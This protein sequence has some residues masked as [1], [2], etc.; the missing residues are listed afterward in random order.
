[1][2]KPKLKLCKSCKLAKPIW[3]D[4]EC[5]TCYL[6]NSGVQRGLPRVSFKSKSKLK[7]KRKGKPKEVREFYAKMTE[8]HSSG[9][10]S[11]ESGKPIGNIMAVNMAHIF[12]KER[13]KSLATN[14][15][16]IVILTWEEHTDFDNLLFKHDF[17]RLEIDFKNSWSKICEI[18]IELLPLCV[19]NGKLKSALIKYLNYDIE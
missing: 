3:S 10:V 7:T 5:S 12:P 13:Y 18:I 17:N 1:M 14:P 6:I 11:I 2:L 4:G 8:K 19:E 9:G 15:R 16:N